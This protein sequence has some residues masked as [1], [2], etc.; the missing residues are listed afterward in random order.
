M[1]KIIALLIGI[2]VTTS[3]QTKGVT[4]KETA[5]IFPKGTK[6]TN[7]NFTGN[8]WLTMLVENDTTFNTGIGNVTFEPKARTNWHFHKGGQILLVTEGEGLY[9][10]KGKAVEVIKKGGVIKCP[11][12]VEHWHGATPTEA[13]THIAIGT[14]TNVGGAVWLKPVSD[15][16]YNKASQN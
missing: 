8:V 10:E 12:N 1:R 15:E 6:V 11:P 5:E 2:A 3:C 16:E 14:N 13:M 9:Q 4:D 7:N